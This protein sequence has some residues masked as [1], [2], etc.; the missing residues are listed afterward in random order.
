[1]YPSDAFVVGPAP[2]PTEE[3]KR[4]AALNDEWTAL[5][6][7]ERKCADVKPRSA[8][9]VAAMNDAQFDDAWRKL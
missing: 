6:K 4:E 2:E 7:V 8:E 9:E 1:M 3:Q 5:G